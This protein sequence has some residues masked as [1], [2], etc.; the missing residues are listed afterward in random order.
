MAATE[1][2]PQVL[3]FWESWTRE[4]CIPGLQLRWKDCEAQH[5]RKNVRKA[6]SGRRMSG[7]RL[8]RQ[9]VWTAYCTSTREIE[10]EEQQKELLWG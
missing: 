5:T 1:S 8:D 4:P 6:E 10:E 2:D 9:A 3:R 7:N